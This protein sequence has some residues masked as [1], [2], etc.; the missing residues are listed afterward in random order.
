MELLEAISG[1]ENGKTATPE[2]Q[3]SVLALVRRLEVAYPPPDDLLSNSQS[4]QVLGGVWYLRYTSPS[5]IAEVDMDREM[6]WEPA[7][8]GETG[9]SGR[10][11]RKN[12]PFKAQGTI[13]AAGVKVDITNQS[14][15]T[16]DVKSS[17]VKNDVQYDWGQ[18]SVEGGF[19]QD[20][21]VKNRVNV[22]FDTANI[23]MKNG[24]LS[25]SFGWIFNMLNLV[26]LGNTD[27]PW[28][29]TT[30]VDDEIRIGRGHKG[31]M[32]VLTREADAVHS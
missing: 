9:R 18:A 27:N 30:F 12:K 28:L 26:R 8:T 16:I 21:I 1:T 32:F 22:S 5:E 17:R 10:S 23:S 13:T 25:I 24:L 15:Q 11:N 20:A 3:A 4:S 2:Q 31:T 7:T 29:E 19:V 14:R 6:L